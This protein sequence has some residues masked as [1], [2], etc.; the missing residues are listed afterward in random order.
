MGPLTLRYY[1]TLTHPADMATIDNA[2]HISIDEPFAERLSEIVF[3]N[4]VEEYEGL[5]PAEDVVIEGLFRLPGDKENALI[6]CIL[7]WYDHDDD[8]IVVSSLHPVASEPLVAYGK[9]D[10]FVRMSDFLVNAILARGD[11][12]DED[13]SR[14][15]KYVQD[16]VDTLF[17]LMCET[18]YIDPKPVSKLKRNIAAK[19]AGHKKPKAYDWHKLGWR[20][21]GRV[22]SDGE[23][24]P[25]GTGSGKA[26]HIRRAHWRRYDKQTTL[27]VR[28]KNR[29]GWWVWIKSHHAGDPAVGVVKKAYKPMIDDPGESTPILHALAESRQ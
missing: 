8:L 27:G 13:N 28:R 17:T 21:A 14:A 29:D 9:Q 7:V 22:K 2:M 16:T 5:M 3:E 6:D 23:S 19:K 24:K 20:V 10:N 26:Y 15:C 1:K 4:P 12:D 25:K 11:H 18:R